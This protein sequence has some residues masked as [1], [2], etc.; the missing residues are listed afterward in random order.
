MADPTVMCDVYLSVSYVYEFCFTSHCA[1]Y[2]LNFQGFNCMTAGWYATASLMLICCCVDKLMVGCYRQEYLRQKVSKYK[3]YEDYLNRVIE[4][5][6]AR[7][8]LTL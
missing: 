8:Y 5:L 3:M 1:L 2:L 4:V 6:P 7:E